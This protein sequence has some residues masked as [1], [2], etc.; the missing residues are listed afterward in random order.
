[1]LLWDHWLSQP[2]RGFDHEL[3]CACLEQQK[4]LSAVI[5][6]TWT[7]SMCT[8]VFTQFTLDCSHVHAPG[9]HFIAC[10]PDN[11]SKGGYTRQ[12][13]ASSTLFLSPHWA[14]SGRKKEGGF[15]LFDSLLSFLLSYLMSTG[16]VC[17]KVG[18]YTIIAGIIEVRARGF[19]PILLCIATSQQHCSW[20]M[21][22]S[23]IKSPWAPGVIE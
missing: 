15:T 13:C 5:I 2:V 6:R 19:T 12:Q 1:M 23:V 18:R 7:V 14:P 20:R 4:G 17:Y 9:L 22:S 16:I 10:C 21:F 3:Y 11:R 8:P